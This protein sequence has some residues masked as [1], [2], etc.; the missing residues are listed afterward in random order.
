M[1]TIITLILVFFAVPF[2]IFSQEA[3]NTVEF[4]YDNAGNRI[5]RHAI[6]VPEI[7]KKLDKQVDSLHNSSITKTI[8]ADSVVI[9]N[10][11]VSI[12]PNPTLGKFKVKLE[13]FR[14]EDNAQYSLFSLTG[15]LIV[16][17]QIHSSTTEIDLQNYDNGPYLFKLIINGESKSW[18]IIKR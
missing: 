18:R 12:Y 7:S 1:K 14:D 8:V 2:C 17:G 11:L 4:K 10:V 16:E 15:Q 6:Y 5:I 9:N 13:N 3:P